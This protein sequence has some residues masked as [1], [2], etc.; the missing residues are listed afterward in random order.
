MYKKDIETRTTNKAKEP[1]Y[2]SHSSTHNTGPFILPSTH[3]VTSKGLKNTSQVLIKSNDN[4]AELEF[5]DSPSPPER[6][7]IKGVSIN[8]LLKG[9]LA[10][11]CLN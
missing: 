3:S 11:R 2:I 9:L 8:P 10:E 6:H 7:Q 5:P 1:R 4:Q